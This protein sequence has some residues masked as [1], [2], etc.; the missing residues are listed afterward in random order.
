MSAPIPRHAA[1]IL[2]LGLTTVMA[3]CFLRSTPR[4]TPVPVEA[5]RP[6]PVATE[7]QQERVEDA[8]AAAQA[9]DYQ[10]ALDL[11]KSLLAENPTLTTAFLGIGEIH[12]ARGDY[13]QAEPAYAR[14]VRLEPGNFDA[15]YGH[16]R[17]L[18]LLQR[19]ADAVRA[20]QRALTIRPY[21]VDANMN[22]ATAYLQ[23]DEPSLAVPFAEK[24]VELAPDNGGARVNLGAAYERV[25][26]TAEAILQ[27][28][29]ALELTEPSVPLLLNLVNAYAAERRFQE[30]IN[31]A[32]ILVSLE[33]NANAYERMGFAYFRL[34]DYERSKQAYREA[35]RLDPAHWPSWNGIGVNS[36][37]A[38]LSSERRDRDAMIEAR[39][40]FRAS[41]RINP[42]QPKVVAL[43]GKYYAG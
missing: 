4:S 34:G 15:Q 27:Y 42:D 41:L 12:L 25:G 17:V 32:Q 6:A 40:A 29:M 20:Y 3:G 2:G 9:G 33:A 30:A 24:A 21:H 37:N 8:Q 36:L 43:L 16:G 38:W 35:V 39:D 22:L 19:F 28:E 11:F 1:V 5:A 7:S 14:A 31:A 13:A 23:L 26:R 18:Q 10:E